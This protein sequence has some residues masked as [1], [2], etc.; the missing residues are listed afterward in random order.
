MSKPTCGR[1]QN[2][3]CRMA[4][5]LW[6]GLWMLGL[7][8]PGG[9]WAHNLDPLSM[10]RYSEILLGRD[11]GQ[12]YYIVYYGAQSTG[13]ATKFID[14]GP[15]WQVDPEKERVWLDRVAQPYLDG[16]RIMLNGER[17]EPKYK[18]GYAKPAIGHGGSVV[19]AVALVAEFAYAPET[20]RMTA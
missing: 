2:Q 10:D 17:I 19:V 8:L 16:V 14:Y 11:S 9:G 5:A 20:P 3:R 6:I 7:G 4:T 1:A 18:A 13:A 15:S 12:F